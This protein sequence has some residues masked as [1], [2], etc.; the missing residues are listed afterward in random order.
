MAQSPADQMPGADVCWRSSTRMASFGPS[1]IPAAAASSERGRTP[2]PRMTR[3]AS[4]GPSDVRT[5]PGSNPSTPTPQRTSM[6]CDR[7][8]SATRSP[9]S[10]SSRPMRLGRPLDDR[11]RAAPLDV[12]LGHLQADVAAADD[13]DAPAPLV[14]QRQQR[15]GVVEGLHAVDERQVDA[16][17]VG[18][19]RLA[20][21]GDRAARRSRCG[22]SC[23]RARRGTRPRRRRRRWPSPRG[24]CARRCPAG[25]A[26]PG[27]RA[28]S[29]STPPAT[30]PPTRNGMPH[31]E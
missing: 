2:M 23:R 24:G 17:Q 9:K 31:A 3:S 26:R 10:A 16:R 30:R 12:G 13:D 8:A 4:I 19:D 22:R 14:G 29:A 11:R 6:P 15:L 27:V 5:A 7:M 21:G 28:T 25:G 20:A 1:S 18:A